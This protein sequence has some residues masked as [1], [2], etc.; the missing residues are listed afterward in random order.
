MIKKNKPTKCMVAIPN[1][2]TMTTQVAKQ[3]IDM[4]AQ[5][6]LTK[7]YVIDMRF[8]KVTNIDYNRNTIVKMFLETD[9]EWLLMMD[10][11]N[12]CLQ[13]PLDLIE[14]N[15]DIIIFPTLMF[16]VDLSG[17]PMLQYNIFKKEGNMWR[18]QKMTPGKPLAEYDAGGTGC[19]LIKRK[20]L[21]GVKAPFLSKLNPDGTR[22]VGMDLWFCQKAKQRG[23]RIWA[24][25]EYACQHIKDVDLLDVARLL[26]GG[27]RKLPTLNKLKEK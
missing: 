25:W 18:S 1:Q 11:D 23:F 8:S 17:S 14:L 7:K 2:G 16:K 22:N 20:V 3:L 5:S 19:I 21:E 24:H 13:N 27:T 15:K 12:P 10:D 4:V 26:L 6:L 9:N